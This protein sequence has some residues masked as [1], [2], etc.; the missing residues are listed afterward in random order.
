[1]LLYLSTSKNPDRGVLSG[2]MDSEFA[3]N[4]FVSGEYKT[5]RTSGRFFD[6]AFHR[7]GKITYIIGEPYDE[8]GSIPAGKLLTINTS[9]RVRG[10][11]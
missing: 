2:T 6:R 1:M 8:E 9:A 10:P 5:R 11:E 4:Q 3:D 7:Q